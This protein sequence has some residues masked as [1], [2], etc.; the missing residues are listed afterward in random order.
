VLRRLRDKRMVSDSSAASCLAREFG[1]AAAA[2][3]HHRRRPSKQRQAPRK[4]TFSLFNALFE[5]LVGRKA[6]T[7]HIGKRETAYSLNQLRARPSRPA[8]PR[9]H[10]FIY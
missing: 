2:E 9:R 8:P 6:D 7:W 10:V 3:I 4:A 5:L 1:A